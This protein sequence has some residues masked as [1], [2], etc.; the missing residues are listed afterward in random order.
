MELTAL[1]GLTSSGTE[2]VNI[3]IMSERKLSDSF[4]YLINTTTTLTFNA[5]QD[6]VAIT[7]FRH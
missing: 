7:C 1:L 2:A 6:G 3:N 4:I 5:A